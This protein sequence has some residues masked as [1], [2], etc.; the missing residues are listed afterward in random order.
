MYIYSL[1]TLR[2]LYMQHHNL[3][4]IQMIEQLAANTWPAPI[5][6]SYEHWRL[7]AGNGV[8]KRA[9]SVL[10]SGSFPKQT[11]WLNEITDFYTRQSLPVRFHISAAT[12][13]EVDE[14]LERNGFIVEIQTAVYKANCLEVL[15]Q[16]PPPN[17][18]FQIKLTETLENEWM[19]DFLHLEMHPLERKTTYEQIFLGISPKTCYLR[20]FENGET[21]GLG[22]A[23]VEQGWAGF[24]NIVTSENFRKRGIGTKVM[25]SL[26]HWCHLNGAE[27]LYLQVVRN[28]NA[29]I[30][31][32]TKLG[33]SHVFDYHYRARL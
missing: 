1:L 15:Q 8:T 5:Q 10:T 21:V 19:D 25:Q 11:N 32:Y 33:F 17:N 12:D 23:V 26:I 29:A 14:F 20:L 6:Q 30:N 13:P 16:F 24:T 31:L 7:R 27:N 18:T 2:R 3:E 9:N 22:T 4:L 28:N